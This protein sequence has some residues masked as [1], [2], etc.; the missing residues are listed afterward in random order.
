MTLLFENYGAALVAFV[1]F[2]VFHSV[3]AHEPLKHALARWTSPFWVDHFWRVAYCS[4]SFGALYGGVSALLWG[5]NGGNNVW[6][7]DYPDWL[8]QALTI[9]HLGSIGLLYAAFLQS[10]YLEFL[11]LKQA[12]RG[13]RVLAGRAVEP[14]P[15]ALFGSQRLV[16]TGV[17]AWVRHPMLAGGL[18]FLLT[19]G[20]SANNL[21]Y[22]LMY[23]GYML[24]GG[25]YEERRMVKIFGDDYLSYRI[26]VGA[27]C[28]RFWRR[29]VT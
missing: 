29:Q 11:G 14:T 20:P 19:S 13:L 25:Y 17:Y 15:V 28:P 22:T 27:F 5:R 21:V 9:L 2:A 1:L 10:D 8:W 24:L 7:V 3:G 16:T 23:T 26:R 12:W 4:L 18:L 6:L